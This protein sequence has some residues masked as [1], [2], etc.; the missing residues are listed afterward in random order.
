MIQNFSNNSP[1]SYDYHKSWSLVIAKTRKTVVN[2]NSLYY[3]E[4]VKP[5][6]EHKQF[7]IHETTFN[8]INGKITERINVSVQN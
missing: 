5:L 6:K 7:S 3:C 8:N 4:T 1:L 2:I